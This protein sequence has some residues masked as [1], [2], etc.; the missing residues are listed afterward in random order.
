MYFVVEGA[1]RI[2]DPDSGKLLTTMARGSYFG[3]FALLQV[4]RAGLAWTG[5]AIH[6][7][8]RGCWGLARGP[9]CH[10]CPQ[11]QVLCHGDRWWCEG[12]AGRH[13]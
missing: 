8:R 1:V 7:H 6:C 4:R 3:E 12:C 13:H 2:L 9:A 5:Q 10:A 11:L